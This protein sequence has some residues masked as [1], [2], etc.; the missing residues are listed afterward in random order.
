MIIDDDEGEQISREGEQ[1]SRE[2]LKAMISAFLGGIGEYSS[3]DIENLFTKV[4]ADGSGEID[5]GEFDTF[6][7]MA[8]SCDVDLSED[9]VERKILKGMER[10]KSMLS[11]DTTSHS[12]SSP[13]SDIKHHSNTADIEKK[14]LKGM[15]RSKSV[16]SMDTT[17]HSISS[18][19][20][21]ITNH[22]NEALDIT[23]TDEEDQ[24]CLFGGDDDIRYLTD[25][26]RDKDRPLQEWSL[27]Y[28]GAS[29]DIEGNL[30]E[31]SSKH[32][33]RCATEK[34]DW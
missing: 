24:S 9:D 15:E 33:I 2:G 25:L 3:D 34:F 5:R 21:D 14:I 22:S 11:M 13:K 23:E 10:T 6:L 20:L 26:S 27:F 4:D 16:L 7:H 19:N 28:C 18:R 17:S 1:I 29:G 30:K 32:G 31:I 12:M 8:T